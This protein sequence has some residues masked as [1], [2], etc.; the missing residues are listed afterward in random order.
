MISLKSPGR[1]TCSAHPAA[2][3]P[4]QRLASLKKELKRFRPD[5]ARHILDRT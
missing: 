5:P 4:Q 2:L 1:I 3:A